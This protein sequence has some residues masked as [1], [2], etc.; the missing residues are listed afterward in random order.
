MKGP[1]A[2]S[3]RRR[4]RWI[5]VGATA[6]AAVL[7]CTASPLVAQSTPHAETAPDAEQDPQDGSDPA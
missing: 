7:A 6:T 4:A 1:A 2:R 3:G 5:A